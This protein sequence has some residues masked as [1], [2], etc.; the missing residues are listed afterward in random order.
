MTM[1]LVSASVRIH[2]AITHIHTTNNAIVSVSLMAVHL[3]STL[4]K[5]LA[6]AAV[7]STQVVPRTNSLTTH[8]VSANAMT[9][10]SVAQD[11]TMTMMLVSVSVPKFLL[12]PLHS[13]LIPTHAIVSVSHKFATQSNTLI[14]TPVAASVMNT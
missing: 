8:H 1:A 14:M 12:A 4:T 7:T 9:L 11:S 3:I 2:R 5:T 13:T 6:A 10:K